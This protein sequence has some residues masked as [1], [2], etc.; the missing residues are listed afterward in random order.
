M[1]EQVSSSRL[2]N[3]ATDEGEVWLRMSDFQERVKQIPMSVVL[4]FGNK[5]W[6]CYEQYCLVCQA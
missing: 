3:D 6:R 1:M 4:L 5:I 2:E